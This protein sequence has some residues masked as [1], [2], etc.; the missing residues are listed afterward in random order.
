MAFGRCHACL[1]DRALDRLEPTGDTIVKPAPGRGQTDPRAG[2]VEHPGRQPFLQP[3]DVPA[4][5]G[6]RRLQLF[7]GTGEIA[8]ATGG[9][10]GDEGT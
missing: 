9:L 5:I 2:P 10:E 1:R 6:L 4:Y 8:E 7:R 3:C